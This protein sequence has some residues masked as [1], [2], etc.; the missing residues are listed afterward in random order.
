MRSNT[1]VCRQLGIGIQT[2]SIHVIRSS[3][4]G[5]RTVAPNTASAASLPV[6]S[7]D[8]FRIT[9]AANLKFGTLGQRFLGS[10][11]ISGSLGEFVGPCVDDGVA[12][13][14]LDTSHDA[15]LELLL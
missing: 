5:T 8:S 1:C 12:I 15:L 7:E 9:S 14:I 3:V 2:N 13:D 6:L 10:K 4:L 11:I